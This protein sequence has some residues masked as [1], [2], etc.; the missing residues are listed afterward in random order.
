MKYEHGKDGDGFT[1]HDYSHKY[2]NKV[3][4]SCDLYRNVC[5]HNMG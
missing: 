2:L 3:I 1:M 5:K 4:A